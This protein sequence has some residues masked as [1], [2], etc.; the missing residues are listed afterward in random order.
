MLI[1][2]SA[3]DLAKTNRFLFFYL[4]LYCYITNSTI[5]HSFKSIIKVIYFAAIYESFYEALMKALGDDLVEITCTSYF[6]GRNL[7]V[8]SSHFLR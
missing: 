7:N 1:Q 5:V 6:F 2:L 8:S 4:F 3:I